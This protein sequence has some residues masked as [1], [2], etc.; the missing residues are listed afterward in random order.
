MKKAYISK[1][2]R[3]SSLALIDQANDI[4][5][6]YIE[7]G[8]DLTLRQLYYQFVAQDLFPE[9]RKWRL[10]DTG[11]WIRD[12]NGTKNAEPNYD[13][14][15]DKINDGRLTGLVDWDVLVDRTRKYESK[16]HWDNPA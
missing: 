1:N 9:D 3:K 12:P 11:K 5:E 4:I 15:G 13:W 2:F 14:L 8:Y 7:D 10:T 16:S 6:T